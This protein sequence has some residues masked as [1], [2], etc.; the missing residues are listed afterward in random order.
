M[1]L[2]QLQELR[3]SIQQHKNN[4]ALNRA[5][6]HVKDMQN[7][8]NPQYNLINGGFVITE[9]NNYKQSSDELIMQFENLITELE[10]V[11][12]QNP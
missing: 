10:K 12:Q 8:N 1:N 2:Q 9:M 6:G 11:L 5:E 7:S 4:E 3:N